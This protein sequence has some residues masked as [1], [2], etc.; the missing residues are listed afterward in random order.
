M[1]K[2]IYSLAFAV[3]AL[4]SCTT[5][6]E[7]VTEN[8]GDG[9]DIAIAVTATTD[10][11]FTFTLTPAAGT[12]F[13]NFIV[14]ENPEPEELDN[15]MLLKGSYG[16]AG[17]LLNAATDATVTLTVG[18]EPNTTYQIYAVAAN[19]KGIV[20]AVAVASVTTTDGEAPALDSD[21][22]EQQPAAKAVD[23]WF[24]QDL[25]RGEGAVTAV[26]YK[27]WDWENPVAVPADEI[28]VTV[29]GPK[30]TFAAPTTPDGAIVLF[31]WAQGAF[32][33]AKGNQ[34]GAFTTTYDEAT[35][36]FVGA[37][38]ENKKVEFAIA[39]DY[40]TAPEVGSAFRNPEQFKGVINFGFDIFRIDSEVKTGD[41]CVTYS[42]A[43]RTS[44]V[45]LS[46]DQWSVAGQELTFTLPDGIEPNDVVT[47]SIKGGV[48][49]DVYGNPNAAYENGNA[50]WIYVTM[51]VD[52]MVGTY[53]LTYISYWDE[54]ATPIDMGSFTIAVD[55]EADNGLI[56]KDFY[57]KGSVM[58]ATCN[59][60]NKTMVI[61]DMQILGEVEDAEGT[62]GLV[63]A[64]ADGSDAAVFKFDAE[65][66]TFSPAG[67]WGVYA[68]DAA[69]EEEIGWW[70]AAATSLFSKVE[71][72]ASRKMATKA[73][74]HAFSVKKV[75]AP[76]SRSLTK[77]IR[78]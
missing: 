68:F 61:P 21:P 18:A 30:A 2:L 24:D 16:N 47:V 29:N 33:D 55:E 39:D 26:Y 13:Y 75:S 70:D 14:D 10:N 6:E 76:A 5:W 15:T 25:I 35:D 22:F 23:V 54:T 3:A 67:M 45:K 60:A 38:V 46:A 19:D 1:K 50:Q 69:Y 57:V 59:L 9:P 11:S 74:R 43:L 20:G 4:T 71:A 58:K 17:N 73:G 64:T 12:Q 32:V 48:F 28:V 41:V 44:T 65:A 72:A 27:E 78:K 63:F 51:T 8:Y 40:F 31:S 56:I 52:E 37:Y 77:H 36:A 49:Y 62:Y 66:G 42:G 53:N 34:C 7:P